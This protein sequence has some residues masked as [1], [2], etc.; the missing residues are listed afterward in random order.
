MRFALKAIPIGV[1]GCAAALL[2]ACGNR[3]GLL[4]GGDASSL[5]NALASVQSACA[6]GKTDRAALAAQ[7]FSDRVEGL[8]SRSVDRRLIANLQQ[9]ARTLE[10]LVASRCTQTTPTTTTPTTAPTTTQATT[11]APTTTAP[12]QTAPTTT[13][14]PTDTTTTPDAGGGGGLPP[15]Q[16]GTPP[17]QGGT[18][19]GQGGG[20]GGDAGGASPGGGG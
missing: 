4:S 15:G 6:D 5:Q 20:D 13:A 1:L 18:P 16:G 9:G 12:T 19:P 7:R 14:P 8:S 11:T 17:G 2:V 3:N 10:Q